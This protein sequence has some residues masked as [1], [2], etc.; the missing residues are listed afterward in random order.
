ML[1]IN[2]L[3]VAYGRVQVLFD[4]SISVPEG[5]LVTVIGANGAGKTTLLLTVSGVLRPQS[6]EISFE[7]ERIDSLRPHE[8]VGMGLGHV[9]QG[10]ELF[11]AM[12][13][14]ENLEM[15]AHMVNEEDEYRRRLE[16]A[17]EFFP[18][19][20]ERARQRAGTLSG[21]EQQMLAIARALMA[22]PRL[23]LLD[24]PS[25][26]LAPIIVDHLAEI[27]LDLNRQGLTVLLVEQNA[28]LALEIARRAYVMESGLVVE[29]GETQDVLESDLVRRA[30]LGI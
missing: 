18:R 14:L 2:A 22:E 27:I 5:E 30:Y 12:T 20:S 11:P 24:E 23:L 8:I 28:F 7:G 25:A 1:E 13:V 4:V 16:R 26:G 10:K 19:L 17:F 21:G 9:P 3:N 29:S 6:G 15:G